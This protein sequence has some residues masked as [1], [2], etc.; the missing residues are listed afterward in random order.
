[1]LFADVKGSMELAE[2]LDPEEGYTILDRFFQSGDRDFAERGAAGHAGRL[3]RE[4][5][6]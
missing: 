6:A 5:S 1:V 2:Q 3:A 4:L